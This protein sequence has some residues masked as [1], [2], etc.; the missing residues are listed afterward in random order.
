MAA[1]MAACTVRG[2]AF[3]YEEMSSWLLESG[4]GEVRLIEPIAAQQIFVATK[5]TN[6]H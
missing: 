6:T 4:F 1:T 5:P 2:T 3:S